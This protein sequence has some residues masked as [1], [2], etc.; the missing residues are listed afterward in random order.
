[1]LSRLVIVFLARSKH[2]LISWLQSTSAVILEP[3][4]IK[5]ITVSI[6]SPSICHEVMGLGAMILV[7]WMLSF[8]P[9]FFTLLFHLHQEVL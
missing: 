9:G 8:K 7:F 2:L 5:S 4:K 6:V 3:Q 1:M